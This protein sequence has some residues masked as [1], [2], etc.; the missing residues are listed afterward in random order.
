[1]KD[2]NK[3]LPLEKKTFTIEVNGTKKDVPGIDR[4][5]I[6]LEKRNFSKYVAHP[7]PVDGNFLMGEKETWLELAGF[8][9]E[10]L[11]WLLQQKHH[12]FWSHMIFSKEAQ[13]LLVTF[14]QE[15]PPY[16]LRSEFPK[17][18]K[19]EKA[20]KKIEHLVFLVFVR[21]STVKE[22]ETDFVI[23]LGTLLYEN[24]VFTVPI[25]LDIC[26]IYGM[27]NRQLVVNMLDNVISVAPQYLDDFKEVVP[28]FVHVFSIVR[29]KFES[30]Q[31]LTDKF[32]TNWKEIKDLILHLYDSVAT[33]NLFLDIYSSGSKLFRND[34]FAYE[35]SSFYSIVIPKI[36]SYVKKNNCDLVKS[37]NLKEKI[38]EI[39]LNLLSIMRNVFCG[40]VND[41]L[42]DCES[43]AEYANEYLTQI[44][45]VL[46]EPLFLSDYN[47][48]Y[49][50]END[51]RLLND[52]CP[53]VD[54]EAFAYVSE[55]IAPLNKPREAPRREEVTGVKAGV[56]HHRSEGHSAAFG[57]RVRR[58]VH[59]PLQLQHRAGDRRHTRE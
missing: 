6:S 26:L 52:M 39:R 9:I 7:T 13:Q 28:H 51:L 43:K 53:D 12:I 11:E 3:D 42:S 44:M 41:V 21:L 57:G 2:F 35:V 4:L 15:A 33:I 14:L 40:I 59:P 31:A 36:Y 5:W 46:Q 27:E 54:P 38:N 32:S 30:N 19:M 23:N 34:S 17:D 10:D 49:P 24:Y 45:N 20:L 58:G 56:T 47:S 18:E 29:D 48:I 37:W 55:A 16:Y 8:V 22:S 25:L 50:I 1:M